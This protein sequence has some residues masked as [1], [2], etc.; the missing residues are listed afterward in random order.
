MPY[1]TFFKIEKLI[2][3]HWSDWKVHADKINWSDWQI[4]QDKNKK[5][6]NVEE[7]HPGSKFWNLLC[8]SASQARI[9]NVLQIAEQI[10]D[11]EV[12]EIL[13]CGDEKCLADDKIRQVVNNDFSLGLLKDLSRTIFKFLEN[14]LEQDEWRE[15]GDSLG[16]TLQ[17]C[18]DFKSPKEL[19]KRWITLYPEAPLA[20]IHFEL[21]RLNYLEACEWL[22][23]IPLEKIVKMPILPP[24][25]NNRRYL[26]CFDMEVLK[27]Y[28][29]DKGLKLSWQATAAQIGKKL[30]HGRNLWQHNLTLDEFELQLQ[31][32]DINDHADKEAKL[33]NAIKD[34]KEEIVD[35]RYDPVSEGGVTYSQVSF[36]ATSLYKGFKNLSYNLSP[37]RVCEYLAGKSFTLDF[38]ILKHDIKINPV[39][40]LL[41][42]WQFNRKMSL[43]E[44]CYGVHAL[45]IKEAKLNIKQMSAFN[46]AA[47]LFKE[48]FY[49]IRPSRY[50]TPGTL[51]INISYM[52]AKI[53]NEVKAPKR[54]IEPEDNSCVVCWD[55]EISVALVPCG[56]L[57]FCTECITQIKVCSICK[58][59]F[60]EGIKIYHV[61]K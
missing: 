12:I 7:E 3:I 41:Y 61:K 19:L 22:L 55:K 24:P 46:H 29:I 42:Y 59:P 15:F 6:K 33:L 60:R 48:A 51:P 13:T 32:K 4:S 58:A 53:I 5:N 21:N 18:L 35:G 30:L 8:G 47:K 31:P 20:R 50:F 25:L 9:K 38:W 39:S 37:A 45:L 11:L 28:C 54:V 14:E 2:L 17:E 27:E 23:R 43:D 34:L 10:K 26:T 36:L 52:A 49:S 44:F 56:H 1:E 57:A 40:F 16:F